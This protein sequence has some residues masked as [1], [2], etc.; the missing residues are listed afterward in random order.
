MLQPLLSL[1]KSLLLPLLLQLLF[2]HRPRPCQRMLSPHAN[3]RSQAHRITVSLQQTHPFLRILTLGAYAAAS[4]CSPLLQR[5]LLLP[6]L[7]LL[8]LLATM[9]AAAHRHCPPIAKP[10]PLS[11]RLV[12]GAP[13]FLTAAVRG[14]RLPNFT[15]TMG[16]INYSCANRPQTNAKHQTPNTKQIG[17]LRLVRAPAAPFYLSLLLYIFFSIE[18]VDSL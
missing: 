6:A 1:L 8:P 9:M 18:S 2:C 16:K 12:L 11:C 13:S 14:R 10:A 15:T 4:H 7:L 17:I 5:R 3:I